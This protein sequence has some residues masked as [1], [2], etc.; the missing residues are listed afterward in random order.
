MKTTTQMASF[1][2]GE[3]A[4]ISSA[5]RPCWTCVRR[6]VKCD[7]SLPTCF[8]CRSNNREC[9]GYG[10]NKPVRLVW[11]GVPCRKKANGRNGSCVL[12]KSTASLPSNGVDHLSPHSSSTVSA[13]P[14]DPVFQDLSLGT[15]RNVQY[16]EYL[17][18]NNWTG[19]IKKLRRGSRPTGVLQRVHHLRG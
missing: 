6:R 10:S 8:K 4:S 2:S 3:Y 13:N 18:T 7:L 9:L 5:S 16:C 11:T 15:R 1:S 17:S 14:T 12:P 19:V